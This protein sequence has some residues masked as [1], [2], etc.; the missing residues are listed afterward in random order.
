MVFDWGIDGAVQVGDT[1]YCLSNSTVKAE[2][3]GLCMSEDKTWYY[4]EKGKLNANYTG[5]VYYGKD[6]Y[7]VENGVLNWGYTGFTEY[8]GTTYYVT[9]GMLV[10]GKGWSC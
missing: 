10:W 4:V 1:V 2:Y 6:W 5:L 7:Y 9:N 3:T 8:C